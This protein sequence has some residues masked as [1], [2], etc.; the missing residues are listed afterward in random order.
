M[1]ARSAIAKEAWDVLEKHYAGAAQLKKIRLQTMRRKYELM[2]MEEGE[3]VA[4]FFTRLITHINS[5]KACGE[6]MTD[7]TIVEKIL[8]TV[9]PKFDYVVVAIEESRRVENMKIE[10]L[11]GSLEAH[12]QRLNEMITDRSSHQVLQ[13]QTTKKGGF[14][15]KNSSRT[16]G[17]YPDMKGRKNYVNNSDQPEQSIRRFGQKQF[18]GM[19]R[20]V[21]KKKVRCYNCDKFGHYSTECLEPTKNQQQIKQ[22][23]EA[24]LVKEE[25]EDFE[26]EV[27][28]LMMTTEC[29][30]QRNDTWYLDS[31]CS[32]HMTGHKEWL[33]NFDSSKRNKVKFADNRVVITEGSGD[34][35]LKM[36]YGSKAYITD[37]LFVPEMKTNP[38]SLGQ[39]HEKGFSMELNDGV[40]SVYDKLKMKILQAP[41]SNNRTFQI[42]LGIAES[43][44]LKAETA[45]NETWL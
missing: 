12:E 19:R 33:V 14:C 17:R 34:I 1:I 24:N 22:D 41:L 20:K 42:K 29:K 10:E 26:E 44:C 11:Q 7:A 5:M 25:N 6:K 15:A 21:D 40:M 36:K 35:P 8:R 23:S 28:Q 30:S 37:V 4:D 13:M 3:K 31:G 39:L 18:K 2:Q 27:V 45:S 32:N 16:Q 9:S 43:Q 38:I